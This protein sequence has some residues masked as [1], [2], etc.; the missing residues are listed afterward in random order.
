MLGVHKCARSL[1]FILLNLFYNYVRYILLQFDHKFQEKRV[2]N[3]LEKPSKHPL[4]L[5][6]FSQDACSLTFPTEPGNSY[7]EGTFLHAA[8]FV[9]RFSKLCTKS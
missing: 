2:D 9:T 6:N 5:R 1:Q 3:I 7:V 8:T 4:S